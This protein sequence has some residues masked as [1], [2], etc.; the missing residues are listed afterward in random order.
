M[1][2]VWLSRTSG[3]LGS[4]DFERHIEEAFALRVI[5]EEYT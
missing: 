3:R 2:W 5:G 4:D 1:K